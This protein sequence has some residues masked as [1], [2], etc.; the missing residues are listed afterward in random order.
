MSWFGL[1]QVVLRPQTTMSL[2]IIRECAKYEG[3]QNME[4]KKNIKLALLELKW[5][6]HTSPMQLNVCA[7]L[8]ERLQL[9]L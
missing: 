4:I 2:L 7:T 5:E 8:Q 6:V 9:R 3:H 1:V